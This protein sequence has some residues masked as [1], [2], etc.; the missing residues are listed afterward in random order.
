LQGKSVADQKDVF[1]RTLLD[2][3]GAENRRDDVS[4]V[5]FRL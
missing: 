2:Y 3:Q 1:R 5:A 4:V